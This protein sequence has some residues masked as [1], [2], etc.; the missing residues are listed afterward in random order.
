MSDNEKRPLSLDAAWTAEGGGRLESSPL[1]TNLAGC[2]DGDGTN[3]FAGTSGDVRELSE[4]TA[5]V[6]RE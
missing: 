6:I 1:L 3:G 5:V 2:R 4:L